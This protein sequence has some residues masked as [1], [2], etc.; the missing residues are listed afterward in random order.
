MNSLRL[1]ALLGLSVPTLAL[2]ACTTS[3]GDDDDSVSD[4]D[5][6]AA[7]DFAISSPDFVAP[8]FDV[9]ANRDCDQALPVANACDGPNPEIVWEGVP[10]GT[11]AFAL[12][13]DDVSFNDYEHWAIF[14]IP[15]TETGLAAAI[16]GRNLTNS[17]PGDAIELSNPG[18]W[19]GYLGSCPGA[20]N[21][22]R[23][24]LWA[25]DSELDA[26]LNSFGAV[27][28]AAEDASIEMVEM[29]HVFDGR[30]I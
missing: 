26:N 1:L 12:I 9:P 19:E 5:D 17:P 29:C 23:W 24:R 11:V 7:V 27:I 10:D 14:N 30:E 22:Y 18:G 20:V 6:A 2:T 13:F 28:A 21:Q 4:D 16:S 8:Y 3:S 15:A 25:L